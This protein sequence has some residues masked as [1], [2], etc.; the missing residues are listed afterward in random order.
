MQD[1]VPVPAGHAAEGKAS[2]VHMGQDHVQGPRYA[3]QTQGIDEQRSVS[4]LSARASAHESPELSRRLSIA[5]RGLI[6]KYAEGVE[7]ALARE[8]L[9]YRRGSKSANQLVL[10]VGVADEEAKSL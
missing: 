2:A 10:E 6:L 8:D 9:L 5:L 4:D 3:S 7:L 1:V